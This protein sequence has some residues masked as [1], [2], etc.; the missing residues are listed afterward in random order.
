MLERS[1]LLVVGLVL[2]LACGI[3]DPKY[4][5]YTEGTGETTAGGTATGTGGTATGTGTAGTAGTATGTPT[6]PSYA[7]TAKAFLDKNCAKSGCHVAGATSPDLST[8]ASAKAG[9]PRSQIR[10]DA[11]TMPPGGGLTAADKSLFKSWVDAGY[12][13]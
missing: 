11:N 1:T 9:G 4:I 8:F 5:D 6:T 2:L 10:I 12:P 7:G 13:Q 3:T